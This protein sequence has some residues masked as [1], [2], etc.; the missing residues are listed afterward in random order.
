MHTKLECSFQFNLQAGTSVYQVDHVTR[1]TA[2]VIDTG[3]PAP[4]NMQ[5][6]SPCAGCT[7]CGLRTASTGTFTDGS[8]TSDYPSNAN[9]V[10]IIA[11]SGATQ[12]TITFTDFS[13][14]S[15]YDFVVVQQCPDS[16]CST[17]LVELARLSGPSAT[18]PY[19]STTGYMAV[20]FTSDLIITYPGFSASWDVASYTPAPSRSPTQ[21]C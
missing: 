7:S 1:D 15:G 16:S 20:R 9:C 19:T 12:V 4:G 13:T 5:A 8:G 2:H 10:W 21:V 18:L 17:G 11:P 3:S 14:E 6:A